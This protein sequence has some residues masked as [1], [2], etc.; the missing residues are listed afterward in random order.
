M[1]VKRIAVGLITIGCCV[2]PMTTFAQAATNPSAPAQTA[3]GLSQL[4]AYPLPPV[5][6]NPLTASD[7]DL[8]KYGFPARPSDAQGLAKWQSVMSKWKQ[9]VIVHADSTSLGVNQ[10]GITTNSVTTGT[11]PK[12]AGYLDYN[13]T[14]NGFTDVHAYSYAEPISAPSG[15]QY[16]DWVGFG[17]MQISGLDG[18]SDVLQAGMIAQKTTSGTIFT[19]CYDILPAFSSTGPTPLSG[20]TI[21]AGDQVYFDVSYTTANGGT[22]SWYV[23]DSTTGQATS[24]KLTGATTYYD[25]KEAEAVIEANGSSLG[26][27]SSDAFTLAD[28]NN[29][30]NLHY[31]L[32]DSSSPYTSYQLSAVSQTTGD[33][34]AAASTPTTSDSWTVYWHNAT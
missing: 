17:G 5:G 14:S 7:S 12:W 9:S 24:N 13:S 34:L 8:A 33:T 10:S 22:F 2:G 28:T 11:T 1:L 3:S 6:F 19:P 25:G 23:Q 32:S 31:G 20:L 29:A 18:G 16:A 21:S 4:Q 15:S 27:F 30:G 26:D